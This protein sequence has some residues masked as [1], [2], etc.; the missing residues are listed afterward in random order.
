MQSGG[1]GE[2]QGLVVHVDPCPTESF[3][4]KGWNIILALWS[5]YEADSSGLRCLPSMMGFGP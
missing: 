3:S 2:E 5:F 1:L 4:D